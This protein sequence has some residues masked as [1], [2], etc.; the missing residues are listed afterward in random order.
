[1]KK[2]LTLSDMVG[3]DTTLR[4]SLLTFSIILLCCINLSCEGVLYYYQYPKSQYRPLDL[5]QISVGMSE[6]EVRSVLGPPADVIGSKIYEDTHVIRV[7]E[8][9]E[10]RLGLHFDPVSKV[11]YLYFADDELIQWGRPGDWKAI[12]DKIYEVR[13][14]TQT[15]LTDPE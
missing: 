12:A 11:Y 7:L 15:Q 2:T 4:K 6:G 3:V 1:M 8:Y 9:M 14:G 5:S 10:A 13:I